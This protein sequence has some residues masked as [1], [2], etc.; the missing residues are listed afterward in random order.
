MKK[1]RPFLDVDVK[2]KMIEINRNFQSID[3]NM[4][5]IGMDYKFYIDSNVKDVKIY[6]FRDHIQYRLRATILHIDILTNLLNSIDNELTSMYSLQ[7]EGVSM[8]LHFERR[9]SDISS[10]FDSVIFHIISA[11]DYVSNLVAFLSIKGE[12]NYKWTKLARAVRD[13]NNYL[14]KLNFS[15]TIDKLDREFVGQLYNHRSYL[16]HIGNESRKSSLSI[17]LMEGKVETKIFSSSTF[18]KNFYELRELGKVNDLSISYTL[19]WLLKKTTESIIEIQHKL[20]EYMEMNKRTDEPLFFNI[21]KNNEMI[22]P[23]INFWSKK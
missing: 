13:K 6:K 19:L 7:N 12:H 8:H 14:S 1:N 18:N 22:S 4:I 10:I 2:E 23:S 17:K 15:E 5:A 9:K 21:G 11:F 16:I 20:K 3:N